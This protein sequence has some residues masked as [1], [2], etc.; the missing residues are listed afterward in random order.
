[1]PQETYQLIDTEYDAVEAAEVEV[2]QTLDSIVIVSITSI[3]ELQNTIDLLNERKQEAIDK[4]DAEI[5]L[6]QDRL[7]AITPITASATIT[8]V[9]IEDPIED[10][11]EEPIGG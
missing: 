7:A 1:M 5:Q 2:T 4:F 11:I 9:P 8:Q 10:P 3:Q 6:N